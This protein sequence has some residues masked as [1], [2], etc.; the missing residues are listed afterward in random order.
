M[1]SGQPSGQRSGRPSAA[2]RRSHSRRRRSRS[3]PGCSDHGT[4]PIWRI[5]APKAIGSHAGAHGEDVV[6]PVRGEI[7]VGRVEVVVEG[8]RG[9]RRA[10]SWQPRRCGSAAS[11]PRTLWALRRL[12]LRSPLRPAL[13]PRGGRA[14]A[15]DV[16]RR[17]PLGLAA[18]A[19]ARRA[20]RRQRHRGRHRRRSTACTTPTTARSPSRRWPTTPSPG[21]WPSSA[22]ASPTTSIP[23]QYKRFKDAQNSEFS[24]VGLQVSRHPKGLRV[25]AVYDGSPAKRAGLRQG[26]VIVAADG[27]DLAGPVAAGVRRPRQGPARQRRCA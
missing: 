5:S 1:R 20:R 17:A 2:V 24:G 6:D 15:R 18:G 27:H 14:A 12:A 11:R 9:H 22:T 4:L 19:G 10:R 7:G 13:R 21:S 26:D 3:G 16:G 25:D 8:R 23:P